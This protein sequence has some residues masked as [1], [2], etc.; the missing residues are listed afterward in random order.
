MQARRWGWRWSGTALRFEVTEL[1]KGKMQ[2]LNVH[3][4]EKQ[5]TVDADRAWDTHGGE[6][7]RTLFAS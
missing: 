4:E 1:R 2:L 7:E 5:R 6:H 3:L